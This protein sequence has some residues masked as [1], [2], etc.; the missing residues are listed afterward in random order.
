MKI[1]CILNITMFFLARD[2]T[3]QIYAKQIIGRGNNIL[4]FTRFLHRI[5]LIPCHYYS[6]LESESERVMSPTRE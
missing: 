4:N 6:G 5:L 2:G 3:E 1:C